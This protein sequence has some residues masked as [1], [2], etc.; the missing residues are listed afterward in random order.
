MRYRTR[1]S[2]V[3]TLVTVVLGLASFASPMV[4]AISTPIIDTSRDSVI[5]D[6]GEVDEHIEERV[7]VLQER[8]QLK[9][10]E[11]ELKKEQARE[12]G[13]DA[14]EAALKA[15]VQ[16]CNARSTALSNKLTKKVADAKRHKAVF[17]KILTRVQEFYDSKKLNTPDYA[18]LL[19][20]AKEAGQKATES[21]NTLE[22]VDVTINC[23]QPGD[24]A[25]KIS[26][27]KEALGLTRQNLKDYRTSI[28]NL[29]VAIKNSIK[30]TASQDGGDN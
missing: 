15:R 3:V 21:L 4:R 27:F 19:A 13:E 16:S 23:D 2:L 20:S 6:D 8:N 22:A 18:E 1:I 11:L 9:I 5:G 7:N 14:K 25:I 10:K 29:I 12:L 28:K 24:V 30:D 17:D 26:T